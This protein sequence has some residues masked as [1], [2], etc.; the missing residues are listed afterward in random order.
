MPHF[1]YREKMVNFPKIH[2]MTKEMIEQERERKEIVFRDSRRDREVEKRSAHDGFKV[3]SIV[4]N[5]REGDMLSVPSGQYFKNGMAIG[6][7]AQLTPLKTEN[8]ERA[9]AE[10]ALDEQRRKKVDR[11]DPISANDSRKYF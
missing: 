2:G 3:N 5:A 1:T 7:T 8:Y 11:L 4:R 6:K 10:M 9:K